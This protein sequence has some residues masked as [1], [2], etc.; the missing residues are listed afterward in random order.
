MPVTVGLRKKSTFD[1]YILAIIFRL[2]I[3]KTA[4]QKIKL[5]ESNGLVRGLSRAL[6]LWEP[7]KLSFFE[8][9]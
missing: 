7:L 4:N 8:T 1:F 9:Y 6:A 3:V 2:S 5:M